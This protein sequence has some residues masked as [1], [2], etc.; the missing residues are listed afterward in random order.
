MAMSIKNLSASAFF[1][2]IP[3]GRRRSRVF[4]VNFAPGPSSISSKSQGRT[5]LRVASSVRE[6]SNPEGLKE[7]EAAAKGAPWMSEQEAR[8]VVSEVILNGEDLSVVEYAAN[9]EEKPDEAH[10][11][12]AIADSFLNTINKDGRGFSLTEVGG[13]WKTGENAGEVKV[14]DMSVSGFDVK[15]GVS[16]LA[17]W[18]STELTMQHSQMARIAT[19]LRYLQN[20]FAFFGAVRIVEALLAVF[21]AS[22]EPDF[23]KLKELLNALDPLTIAWLAHNLLVPIEG[24]VNVDPLDLEHVITLKSNVWEEVHKFFERQWK[25]MATIAMA[26]TLGI[27]ASNLP[28]AEIVTSKVKFLWDAL[29]ALPVF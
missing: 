12:N 17:Q 27:V 28:E 16:P 29:M 19:D 1:A 2:N 25:V 21:L 7:E 11:V 6:A 18:T 14:P 3:R 10:P 8:T 5:S 22:P 26:R 15:D 24:I 20:A 4:A 9:E 13:I 23:G